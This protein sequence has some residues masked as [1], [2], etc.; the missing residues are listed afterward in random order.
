[1]GNVLHTECLVGDC[2]T[3]GVKEGKEKIVQSQHT[4]QHFSAEF[5]YANGFLSLPLNVMATG[6]VT[7]MWCS[8]RVL[9]GQWS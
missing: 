6:W 3:V 5:Q 1:M 8:P 7:T 9:S 4:T 2:S